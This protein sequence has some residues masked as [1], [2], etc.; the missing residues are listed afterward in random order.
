[1]KRSLAH[2]VDFHL[3]ILVL[4]YRLIVPIKFTVLFS[5]DLIALRCTVS[6]VVSIPP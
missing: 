3:I 2:L 1:M 6:T 5:I 4:S